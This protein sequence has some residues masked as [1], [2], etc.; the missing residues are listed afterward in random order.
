MYKMSVYCINLGNDVY[1]GSTKQP[2]CTRQ[3]RHNFRLRNNESNSNL[4]RKARELGIEKLELQLIY[5]G[6]DYKEVEH[7]LI[8]NHDCLNMLG[9]TFDRKRHLRLHREAQKRYMLKKNQKI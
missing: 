8:I 4:Y 9:A 1:F 7:D 3:A 2:I 6:S 5:E